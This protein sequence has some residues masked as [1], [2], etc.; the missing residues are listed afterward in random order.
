MN[1]MVTATL[2]DLESSQYSVIETLDIQQTLES[3]PVPH[4]TLKHSNLSISDILD[5]DVDIVRNSRD[6]AKIEEKQNA[7]DFENEV[8]EQYLSSS[9]SIQAM[10]DAY[11]CNFT[12]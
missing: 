9:L 12:I 2:I 4:M 6:Q 11:K 1:H 3:F 7:V 10:P 8:M 5:I